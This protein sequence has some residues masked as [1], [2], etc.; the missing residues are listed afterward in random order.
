MQ[1]PFERAKERIVIAAEIGINHD[2]DLGR[3]LELID[4]AADSGADAVKFQAFH[5]DRLFSR[6]APGFAHT[7]QDVFAQLQ[8]LEVKSAWWHALRE[9]A[10]QRGVYFSASVF[11]DRAMREL[12]EVGVDFVKVASSEIVDPQSVLRLK[13]L[14][15]TFVVATGM[16]FLD[17]V[18]LLVRTLREGGV[19][20]LVLLECTTRYPAP[21]ETV[22][23]GDIPFLASTFGVPAG[24]SDHTE[25]IY[26][27]VAAAA[28]GARW[29]EKHFTLDKSLPG[30]DHRLSATPAEL[31]TLVDAV[32]AIEPSLQTRRK[33]WLAPGEDR[34]RELG[35][36]SLCAIRDIAVGEP[37]SIENTAIKRPA[38][39]IPPLLT[40]HAMGRRAKVPIAAEQWITWEM[41]E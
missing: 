31:R 14:S 20:K 5:A 30:P 23:L 19:E 7:E 29:I 37:L 26:H 15:D 3:A 34:E 33:A 36:R 32:R 24:F 16:A 41:V 4:A 22:R 12:V 6:R 1:N 9:R 39:G 8:A 10:T 40:P 11:D 25:G 17:E 35:R 38:F 28:L 21:P 27:S 18:A 13:S 2:G